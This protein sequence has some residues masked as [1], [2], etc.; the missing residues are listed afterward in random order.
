MIICKLCKRVKISKMSAETN[1]SNIFCQGRGWIWSFHAKKRPLFPSLQNSWF[2]NY[3]YS[4]FFAF[5]GQKSE[6]LS[7]LNIVAIIGFL[8]LE[9]LE[10]PELLRMS[11]SVQ[12]RCNKN[13]TA[14]VFF[15]HCPL[16]LPSTNGMHQWIAMHAP[17]HQCTN[18]PTHQRTNAWAVYMCSRF[19]NSSTA[20]KKSTA[21]LF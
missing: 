2:Q 19:R 12:T 17:T 18:A 5:L 6:Q 9:T 3:Q 14:S 1:L 21:P 20:L 8:F 15:L 7:N 13:I 16:Q 10:F 11:S 4:A